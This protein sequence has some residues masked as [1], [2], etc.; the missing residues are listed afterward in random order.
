MDTTPLT[1]LTIVAEVAV[2]DRLIQDLQQRGAKGYTLTDA[3]GEGSRHRRV[4]DVLGANIKLETIVS[5]KVA[6]TLMELLA[7]QYFPNY[8]VIAYTSVVHVIRGEK[9]V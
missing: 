5:A 3:S 4:S 6:T 7:T 1:L 2:K 9:Y 8:A